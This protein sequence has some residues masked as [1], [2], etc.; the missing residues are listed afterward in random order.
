MNDK[1]QPINDWIDEFQSFML[2]EEQEPPRQVSSRVIQIVQ[3]GLH[4][5]QWRVFAK[6]ALIHLVVGFLVL[7]VCPQF[8]IGLFEGMGLTS[9]LMHF[10]EIVCS[11]ACGA[12]FLGTSM[13]VSSLLLRP[14]EIRV[15]REREFV[16]L[17]LLA[18]VSIFVFALL[19]ATVAAT[20]GLAWIMGSVLGGYTSFE[21]GSRIRAR[22]NHLAW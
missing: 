18:L 1:K 9:L 14:E 3:S 12:L 7:L 15:M 11:I 19:G 16:Q 20:L 22:A 8:G 5:P 10:G 2:V 6:L 4:P 17:T 13:F 21:L